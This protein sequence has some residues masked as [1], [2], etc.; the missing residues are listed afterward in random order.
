MIQERVVR[1]LGRT[2]RAG[3]VIAVVTLGLVGS[4]A[5]KAWATSSS[6]LCDGY[7]GCSVNG[8]TDNGYPAHEYTSYWRMDAG[9]E[10]TNYTA[11]V[12]SAAFGVATPDYLLGNGGEWAVNAAANGVL[13]NHTPSVGARP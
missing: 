12:E 9:D 11:Y 6:I 3:L 13:V 5:T 8:F 10:C 1:A 4:T 7:A 2:A